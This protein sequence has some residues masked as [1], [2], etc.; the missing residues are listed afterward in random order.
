MTALINALW[1]RFN[2]DTLSVNLDL[3]DAQGVGDIVLATIQG[4]QR[5]LRGLPQVRFARLR[6]VLKGAVILQG[7][8]RSGREL[9]VLLVAGLVVA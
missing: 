7:L 1:E 6:L 2:Q 3:Q 9:V 5:K 4:L 8:R